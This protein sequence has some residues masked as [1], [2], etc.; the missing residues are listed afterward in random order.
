MIFPTNAYLQ[1]AQSAADTM[2]RGTESMTKG[3]TS[4][5]NAA[6]GEYVKYK[7]I[8]SEVASS[9]KFYNTIKSFLPKELQGSIDSSIEEINK[10]PNLSLNDKK[11]FWDQTKS[12]LGMSVKQGMDMQKLNAEMQARAGIVGMEQANALKR[13]EE[14][15]RYRLEAEK[16][17]LAN[18]KEIAAYTETLK[19][20]SNKSSK[21]ES[22]SSSSLMIPKTKLELGGGVYRGN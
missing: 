20:I 9:E 21:Q 15:N 14:E 16:Q 17:K 4:G 8:K 3:L 6:V 1:A 5:I 22:S 19:A 2:A 12:F 7:D 11:N 18:E 13:L 10:D